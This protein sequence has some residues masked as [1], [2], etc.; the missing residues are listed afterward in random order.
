MTDAEVIAAIRR[1]LRTRP[2]VAKADAM[3]Q[4]AADLARLD[5]IQGLLRRHPEPET[6]PR[7]ERATE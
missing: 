4:E 7:P 1:I 2:R 5:Q 3:S 6:A